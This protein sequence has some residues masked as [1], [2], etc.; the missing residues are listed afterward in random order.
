[1]RNRN[2]ENENARSGRAV[3]DSQPPQDGAHARDGQEPRS[4]A[5]PDWR[6]ATLA[7]PAAG[8]VTDYFDEGEPSGGAQ[9]GRT[10]TNAANRDVRRP[11][12]SKT[13]EMNRATLESG[14][15]GEPGDRPGRSGREDERGRR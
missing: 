4:Y 1:M 11:Q 6:D 15:S 7:P 2:T 3:T 8:E 14:P 13:R 12:G 9:Q 5:A 10:Q